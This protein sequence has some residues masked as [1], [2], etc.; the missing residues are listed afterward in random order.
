MIE[1]KM[2]KKTVIQEHLENI[3]LNLNLKLNI[4]KILKNDKNE[5]C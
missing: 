4:I 1:I 2:S 3:A 5:N